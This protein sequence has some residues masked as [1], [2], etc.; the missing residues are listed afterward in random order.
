MGDDGCKEK[1]MHVQIPTIPDELREALEDV[2]G[3]VATVDEMPMEYRKRA[4]LF[5]E[6]ATNVPTREYRVKNF[7]EVVRFFQHDSEE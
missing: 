7:V 3:A 5:I 1:V 6:Q 4:F 2:E